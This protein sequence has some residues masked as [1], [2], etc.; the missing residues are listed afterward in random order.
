[1]VHLSLHS[2]SW[3]KSWQPYFIGTKGCHLESRVV[4]SDV[5]AEFLGPW[6]RSLQQGFQWLWGRS[7]MVKDD[8]SICATHAWC[9][10]LVLL[11][12]AE[13][14]GMRH[15]PYD[16]HLVFMILVLG[17]IS[18]CSLEQRWFAKIGSV[19]HHFLVPPL[20]LLT[21][22]HIISMSFLSNPISSPPL[23]GILVR[24]LS[25]SSCPLFPLS[26]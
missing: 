23:R 21:F 6:C 3:H 12:R 5:L 14:T 18:K 1:M 8:L 24:H 4:W 22:R 9:L 17:I 2:V 15:L 19:A 26:S 11:S 25:I 13:F 20:L 7:G 10:T 16:H